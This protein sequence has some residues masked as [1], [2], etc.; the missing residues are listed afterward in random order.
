MCAPTDEQTGNVARGPGRMFSVLK[1][2]EITTLAERWIGLELI[3]SKE[4]S[5]AQKTK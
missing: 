2:N 3:V 4:I 5:L 1:K